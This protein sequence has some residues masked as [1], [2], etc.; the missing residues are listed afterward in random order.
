MNED[1]YEEL[2]PEAARLVA[3]TGVEAEPE[4]KA[5]ASD[6]PTLEEYYKNSGVELKDRDN[7]QG[8][9]PVKDRDLNIEGGEV[10]E[11]KKMGDK[12]VQQIID[13]KTGYKVGIDENLKKLGFGQE[14]SKNIES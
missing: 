8:L 1:K 13:Q 10:L 9:V 4:S 12:P 5:P 2:I 3:Q 6:A 11:D 14:P 7:R